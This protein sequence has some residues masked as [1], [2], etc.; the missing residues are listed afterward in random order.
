MPSRLVKCLA[1]PIG[2][3]CG[4][5][6]YCRYGSC[7]SRCL[8]PSG[9]LCLNANWPQLFT[10]VFFSFPSLAYPRYSFTNT[11]NHCSPTT[12]KV[13]SRLLCVCPSI[14]L[15]LCIMHFHLPFLGRSSRSA[16]KKKAQQEPLG[17]LVPQ[18]KPSKTER[19]T[20]HMLNHTMKQAGDLQTRSNVAVNRISP[21]P[22]PPAKVG[23]GSLDP[24]VPKK[25]SISKRTLHPDARDPSLDYT[26]QDPR[27]AKERSRQY[28]PAS[29]QHRALLPRRMS[30]TRG[31]LTSRRHTHTPQDHP[32]L[33]ETTTQHRYSQ[34]APVSRFNAS[35]PALASAANKTAGLTTYSNGRSSHRKM[36]QIPEASRTTSSL[37]DGSDDTVLITLDQRSLDHESSP[38]EITS[39]MSRSE[40]HAANKRLYH[41]MKAENHN[42]W[43]LLDASNRRADMMVETL[44]AEEHRCQSL[45]QR[46]HQL[47]ATLDTLNTRRLEAHSYTNTE[48][49]YSQQGP[50][51]AMSTATDTNEVQQVTEELEHLRK[52]LA[53]SRNSVK[54]LKKMT[55]DKP[56]PVPGAPSS[57]SKQ[58]LPKASQQHLEQSIRDMLSP[59]QGQSPLSMTSEQTTF[60]QVDQLESKLRNLVKPKPVKPQR[61]SMENHLLDHIDAIVG[62]TIKEAPSFSSLNGTSRTPPNEFEQIQAAPA[63]PPKHFQEMAM[64]PR[65]APGPAYVQE[66]PD[67]D[68]QG[69]PSSSFRSSTPE[70][71]ATGANSSSESETASSPP[72]PPPKSARRLASMTHIHPALRVDTSCSPKG[73]PVVEMTP[74][75]EQRESQVIE[76][77]DLAF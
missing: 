3:V 10:R 51:R 12:E 50:S 69:S 32:A 38:H 29:E 71:D 63:T 58:L 34:S 53:R 19:A 7:R 23:W 5:D 44:H 41:K 46:T 49:I 55:D 40:R 43:V 65:T 75:A 37:A 35:S 13:S 45:E 14:P 70:L 57:T 60:T 47:Q 6:L 28:L 30:V 39:G 42:L 36:G 1:A 77:L 8:T 62:P 52:N 73:R 74:M 20:H 31:S 67:A 17:G 48:S 18:R 21:Q 25:V 54:H 26:Y 56:P 61:C 66:L 76:G 11:I 22:P 16:E 15:N 24:S 59:D 2:P 68:T 9:E 64:R 4:V 72:T 33:A 27:L